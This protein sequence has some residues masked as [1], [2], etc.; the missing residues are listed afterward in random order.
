MNRRLRLSIGLISLIFAPWR[1]IAAEHCVILQYH[2]FSDTTPAITSV[3]PAQFDAHLDYLQQRDFQVL[4]LQQVAE[5]LR[6]RRPLPDRCVSITV[7]DAYVSVYRNAF[8][9]M[10]ERGWPF[11]VFIS[12]EGV[13]RG[14]AAYMTWDQMREMAAAGV[15]FENHGHTHDH[16]IRRQAGETDAGWAS[17]VKDDIDTAQARILEELGQQSRLFAYPYGEFDDALARIVADLGLTGFGQQ[18]GP[19]AS[20]DDPSAL[21]RFPMAAR[22]AELPGFI[23]KVNSLPMP[24]VKSYPGDPLLPLDEWRPLLTLEFRPGS[25][26]PEAIRC[27]VGGSDRMALQWPAE[28]PDTLEVRALDDLPVGRSRYNCTM[29]SAEAGRYHWLSQAWIRRQA[30]GGWYSEP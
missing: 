11:T 27:F 7:D 14:I 1:A 30:D 20:F 12:T 17:R 19:A 21:P 13:D 28:R 2:H 5:A 8:P 23:D 15:R 24:V 26:R 22:Y 4:P 18:S 9:R 3:T 25:Y 10:R 29:P 16:L 6:E